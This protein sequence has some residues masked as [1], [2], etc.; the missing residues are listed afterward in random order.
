MDFYV[1]GTGSAYGVG[2]E[3]FTSYLPV[4]PGTADLSIHRAGTGRG[5]LTTQAALSGGHHYTAVVSHTL[6]SLQER[7]F[8]DQEAPAPAGQMALRVVNATGGVS[9][10]TVY[11]APTRSSTAVPETALP[12]ATGTASAYLLKTAGV[13]YTVTATVADGG[14]SLPVASVTVKSGSG[15]VRTV[16]FGGT[17]LPGGHGAVV[18]FVLTDADAL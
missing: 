9:P 14:L 10:L 7:V 4:S 2:Y 1:N 8:E 18:G 11:V 3:S 15:A 6:G 17:A 12:V 13:D 5:L 16:I